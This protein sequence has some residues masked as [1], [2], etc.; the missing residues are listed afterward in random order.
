MGG[1]IQSGMLA[2]LAQNTQQNTP[3]PGAGYQAPAPANVYRQQQGPSQVSPFV[4]QQ[5]R[6]QQMQPQ[7][8][9]QMQMQRGLGQQQAISPLQSMLS[10]IMSG[11]SP[12]QFNQQGMMQQ[13]MPNSYGQMYRPDMAQVQQNLSRVTPSVQRQ[14]QD[15]QAARIADLEAQLARYNT[16]SGE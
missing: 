15:A 2:R 9:Q 8:P 1:S 11:Y 10:R 16:P 5:Q 14:Q 4:Q 6:M 12:Q 13:N 7:M 3:Q